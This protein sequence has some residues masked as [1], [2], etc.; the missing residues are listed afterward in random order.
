[1]NSTGVFTED[2]KDF[3]GRQMA[4]ILRLRVLK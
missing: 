1:M 4:L 2:M 3:F